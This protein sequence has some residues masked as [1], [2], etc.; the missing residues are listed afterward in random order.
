MTKK[1]IR[2]R[3]ELPKGTSKY[4][5]HRNTEKKQEERKMIYDQKEKPFG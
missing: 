5:Q 4:D 1:E 2:G 3:V